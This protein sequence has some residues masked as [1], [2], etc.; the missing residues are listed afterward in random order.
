M[1]QLL[2]VILCLSVVIGC[3]KSTPCEKEI[4][5]IPEGFR[6]KIIVFFNQQDGQAIQYEDNARV[7]HI[8]STGMLKTQFKK[9]GGCMGDNR[10]QFFYEDSLEGRKP[11]DYFLNEDRKNIPSDKDYVLMSFLSDRNTKPDFVIHLL[12]S[13]NEFKELT[14]SIIDLDPEEILINY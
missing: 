7:Y 3:K 2:V 14:N 11:I 1:K 6:G 13:I 9:N 8:L 12:G 4:Y 5:L 10:I